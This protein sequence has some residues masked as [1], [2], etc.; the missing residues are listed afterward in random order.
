MF[1]ATQRTEGVSTSDLILKVIKYKDDY[2]KEALEKYTPEELGV[3]RKY[4]EYV[5]HKDKEKKPELDSEVTK[6]L[7]TEIDKLKIQINNL[8]DSLK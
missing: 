6:T 2:I 3:T 8:K 4:A 5:K 7:D 1:K